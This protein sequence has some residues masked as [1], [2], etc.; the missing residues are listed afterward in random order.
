MKINFKKEHFDKLKELAVKALLN[1]D[2]IMG[3]LG[4]PINIIELI[5]CTTINSLNNIRL[6][7]AKKIESLE[8]KD[9]WTS[10]ELNQ[11]SLLKAKEQKELV[12]L[13]IG[14]KRYKQEI[15]DNKANKEVLL[16][17]LNVL[18]ESQKTPEDKIKELEDKLA[19]ISQV[20]E[21]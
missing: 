12:N 3:K 7:L 16:E 5:H 21:F 4:T 11:G 2:V 1:N 10:N 18:K 8:E 15:E 13:I 20:E 19:N 6:S 9:E 17:Q 14:Y